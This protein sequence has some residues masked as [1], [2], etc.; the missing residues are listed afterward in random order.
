M[1]PETLVAALRQP[2][3]YPWL[4]TD[5]ELIET[6]VSWVFLAGDRV[7]KIKRPVVYPFVDFRDL[8]S[9]HRSCQDEVRLNRR[10]TDGVYLDVV[11]IVQTADGVRVGG[12]GA[13]V[14]W[15]TLMRRLPA[16]GML[17]AILRAGSAPP[18]LGAR[19]ASRLVPFHRDR[20]PP[21]GVRPEAAAAATQVVTENLAELAPFAP[22]FRGPEQFAMIAAAMRRFIAEQDALLARRAAEGWLRE[23]HGDLRCEHIC[24]E[25]DGAVQIFDCVEFNRNL[26]CA[27][28][29]SDLAFLLMDLTRLG[30]ADATGEL[31]A[32]YDSAGLDLPEALLRFYWAHRALV[33]AKVACLKLTAT[34]EERTALA[35]KAADYVDLA[36]AACLTVRPALIV[37]TGLSGTGKSTVAGRV[38][39]ALGAALFASDVVR[40]KVAGVEG[41]AP[42]AWR[43]GIYRPELTAATYDQLFALAGAELAAGRPAVLDAAF[44]TPEQRA[45]AAALAAQ[46][47]V[48]LVL[49]ETVCAEATVAERLAARGAA[50]TSPSDA[51]L[52]TYRQQRA[53]LD[54]APPPTP[55]G[56]LPVQVD[57]SGSLP[58]SLDP[59]LT[60]LRDAGIVLPSIPTGEDG[61]AQPVGGHQ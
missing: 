39:R 11:P 51:T 33:R 58:I 57:T 20:C 18:D 41:A 60:M 31:R 37:M 27:D 19:L 24:L 13:P 28:V 21:C 7:V 59:V 32:A 23:G 9:R 10:L 4:P 8:A 25:P 22:A 34:H 1:T 17:D 16:S 12:D 36:T 52:A 43:E 2:E 38:A 54:A 30:A 56:A 3:A 49:I 14:E 29:A 42:A 40:K 50:G 53:A 6:H 26:R 61:A 46:H 55:A 48:P 47:A 44:L 15:G 35:V 45:G 5:V